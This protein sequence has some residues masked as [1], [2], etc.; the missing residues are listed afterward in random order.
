VDVIVVER[1]AWQVGGPAL[2]AA[3]QNAARLPVVL[4]VEAGSIAPLRDSR[5]VITAMR[6]AHPAKR[7][8][9]M[10]RIGKLTLDL[11]RKR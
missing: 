3:V 9:T 2:M 11:A 10:M 4:P 5:R 1:P 6:L 8:I 7:P